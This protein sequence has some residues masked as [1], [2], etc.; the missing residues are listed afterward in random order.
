[1]AGR[2][3]MARVSGS[4]S[5]ALARRVKHA[6]DRA[7]TQARTILAKA[8]GEEREAHEDEWCCDSCGLISPEGTDGW[9]QTPMDD[10][11]VTAEFCPRCIPPGFRGAT[12]Q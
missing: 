6:T 4:M 12:H 10:A 2:A 5:P 8:R 7:K 1:M 3:R 11:G 9:L